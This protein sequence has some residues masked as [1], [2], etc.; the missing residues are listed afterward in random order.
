MRALHFR[1]THEQSLPVGALRW[2]FVVAVAQQRQLHIEFA[3]ESNNLRAKEGKFCRREEERTFAACCATARSSRLGASSQQW[4]EVA[5]AQL[6]GAQLLLAGSLRR[7][8]ATSNVRVQSSQLAQFDEPG[9]LCRRVA[10]VF[11]KR[12]VDIRRIASKFIALSL[13]YQLTTSTWSGGRVSLLACGACNMI[14]QLAVCYANR[15]A[16]AFICRHQ[17]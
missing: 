14:N 2:C 4:P 12:R 3:V 8:T 13:V 9:A 5:A 11:R 10:L 1:S 6:H 15:S 16:L 17:F 7:T